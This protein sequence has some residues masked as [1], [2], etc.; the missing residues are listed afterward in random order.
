MPEKGLHRQGFPVERGAGPDDP[1]NPRFEDLY[2]DVVAAGDTLEILDQDELEE[3]LENGHITR[4]EYERAWAECRKLY[5]CL[6]EHRQEVFRLCGEAYRELKAA[7][8]EPL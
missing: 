4:E 5:A 3:A 7:M 6:Q 1:E 8:G 2:L